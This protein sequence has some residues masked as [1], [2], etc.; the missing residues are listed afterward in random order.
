MTNNHQTHGYGT[1]PSCVPDIPKH[2]LSRWAI[3]TELPSDHR[4]ITSSHTDE[5][6]SL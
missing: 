4:V 1:A 3:N 5:K 6:S 2:A